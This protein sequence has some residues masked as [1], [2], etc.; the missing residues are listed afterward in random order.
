MVLDRNLSEISIVQDR[1]EEIK[2]DMHKRFYFVYI[3]DI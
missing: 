2:S 1:V 3:F